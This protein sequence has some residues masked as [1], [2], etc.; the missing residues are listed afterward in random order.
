[1]T[2]KPTRVR[3]A[4]SPT[5]PLHIGGI[6]TALF[7]YFIAKRHKG[8]FILR[9]EDTD[10]TR[11][12]PEA[13]SYI[14]ESLTWLGIDADESPWKEGLYAP[15]RQSERKDLYQD[16]AQLLIKNGK[17]Y[18][19]FDTSEDLDNL[20]KESSQTQYNFSNRLKM[21]NSLTLS[22]EALEEKLK[23]KQ[24]YVIRFK[25]PENQNV[26]VND[27]IRGK[28]VVNTASLDDKVLLKSDG[29]PTYHLANVVDDMLMKISHVI[30]GEEWLSSTPLHVLL[31]EAFGWQKDI[32]FFAHLPLLLK[33]AGKGKLSKRDSQKFDMPIFPIIWKEKNKENETQV[34][35]GF[36]E[37]GYFPEALI[38]FL[39]LLGWNPKN[40]KEIFSLSELIENFDF[41]GINKSGVRFDIEKAKWFNSHYLR[42]KD[43]SYLANQ[44]NEI[45][46]KKN[47]QIEINKAIEIIDFMKDR[48]TFIEDIFEQGNYLFYPPNSYDKKLAKKCWKVNLV[49]VL[50]NFISQIDSSET[51]N[52]ESIQNDLTK[53]NNDDQVKR[54]QLMQ[55]LRLTITGQTSGP[56]A[57]DV[58]VYLGKIETQNRIKKA[59]DSNVVLL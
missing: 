9:L 36:K 4:P 44:L 28:V 53:A 31:Y 17:A 56:N 52:K 25:I 23:N 2:Q 11:Y 16:H 14:K 27:L 30:R 49:K 38:N 32:P 6:R 26:V 55:G 48:I 35:K 37:Y 1:M 20:R 19:A 21:K 45:L 8:Q 50:E 58:M 7:N 18:Y 10:Q 43:S 12:V 42:Q 15:Y 33:P 29:M 57:L 51:W 39:A 54:G 5:G 40:E 46:K 13:E 24:K 41:K 47:I 34:I 3:F 59:I 22:T